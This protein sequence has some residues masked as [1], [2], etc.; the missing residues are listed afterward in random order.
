MKRSGVAA[1]LAGATALVVTT[2]VVQ[3]P[4]RERAQAPTGTEAESQSEQF[5][6]QYK[7]GANHRAALAALGARLGIRLTEQRSAPATGPTAKLLRRPNFDRLP[8]AGT[9]S[10]WRHH[11]LPWRHHSAWSKPWNA[12]KDGLVVP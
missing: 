10:Q 3:A 11:R 1:L 9:W 7:V 6:V 2:L 4:A 8:T 12:I 5:I